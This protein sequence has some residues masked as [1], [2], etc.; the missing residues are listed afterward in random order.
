LRELVLTFMVAAVEL[1]A[2]AMDDC[3]GEFH[4]SSLIHTDY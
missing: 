1:V 3:N 2:N 4:R